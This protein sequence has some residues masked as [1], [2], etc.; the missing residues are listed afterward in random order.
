MTVS[1]NLELSSPNIKQVSYPLNIN[2]TDAAKLS[3]TPP[4]LNLIEGSS[5]TINLGLLE[6]SLSLTNR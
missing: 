1:D 3:F 2:N 6:Q 4:K 5:R